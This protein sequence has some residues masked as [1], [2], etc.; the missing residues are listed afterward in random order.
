M[1][2]IQESCWAYCSVCI[3][4]QQPLP[5]CPPFP[6]WQL[7]LSLSLSLATLEPQIPAAS[8]SCAGHTSQHGP[9]LLE[10][11]YP[12][13]DSQCGTFWHDW[14][15]EVG[16]GH[17][18]RDGDVSPWLEFSSSIS[19][20]KSHWLATESSK[21]PVNSKPPVKRRD[22]VGIVKAAEGEKWATGAP[23]FADLRYLKRSEIWKGAPGF[24]NLRYFEESYFE[25]DLKSEPG[26]TSLRCF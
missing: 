22:A 10:P 8:P 12:L 18:W 24:G 11:L 14:D 2:L 6:T 15:P 17:C 13:W 1:T 16:K 20:V 4:S 25:Q 9:P 26:F 7:S 19:P 23:G 3:H 21:P 5:P